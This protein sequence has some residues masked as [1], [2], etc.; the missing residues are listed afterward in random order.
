MYIQFN[1]TIINNFCEIYD[2]SLFI[3]VKAVL[4]SLRVLETS[5]AREEMIKMVSVIKE[6]SV[7]SILLVNLMKF[8]LSL[9]FKIQKF[10][11]LDLEYAGIN[12]PPS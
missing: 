1:S 4:P 2:L 5:Q 11:M 10:Q 6:T 9:L 12:I 7:V 3:S 8:S